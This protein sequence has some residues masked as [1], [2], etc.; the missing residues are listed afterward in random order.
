[1]VRRMLALLLPGWVGCTQAV[2]MVMDTRSTSTGAA[3]EE[4]AALRLV[5]IQTETALQPCSSL[6]QCSVAFI[7]FN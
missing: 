1:M 6:G 5:A 2:L 7:I 3:A 4:V